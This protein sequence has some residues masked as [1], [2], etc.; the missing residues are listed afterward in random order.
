MAWIRGGERDTRE[1]MTSLAGHVVREVAPNELSL[2]DATCTAYFSRRRPLRHSR[3]EP[4]GLGLELGGVVVALVALELGRELLLRIAD[5]CL[6]HAADTAFGR[7][8]A[9]LLRLSPRRKRELAARRASE[10]G[11]RDVDELGEFVA[12]F[13]ATMDGVSE[14]KAAAIAEAARAW[15]CARLRVGGGDR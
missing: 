12:G 2:L 1:F 7:L 14:E 10:L 15:L 13:A 4:L 6:D 5:R 11:E 8:R 3:Q 9:M